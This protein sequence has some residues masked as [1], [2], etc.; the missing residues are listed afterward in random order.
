MLDPRTRAGAR[1]LFI[2]VVLLS[3]ALAALAFVA[4]VPSSG[5]EAATR[6]VPTDHRTIQGAVDHASPGDVV[7]V[8]QGIYQGSVVIPEELDDEVV[9]HGLHPSVTI[10][11]LSG[12]LL[13]VDDSSS[14]SRLFTHQIR[15][16]GLEI[17]AVDTS[18]AALDAVQKGPFSAVV[19]GLD[20]ADGS[21][22]YTVR[23][24]REVGYD[25]PILVFTAEISAA[26]L[27]DV[28]AA[29]ANELLGKPYEPGYV[30]F[31]LSEWLQQPSAPKA[32]LSRFDC[33][34]GMA[35]LLL[36]YI[37]ET[38]RLAQCL[39]AAIE[40]E[41]AAAVR[42]LC[43]KISGSG[44]HHGFDQLSVA[45]RDALWNL[46][47]AGDVHNALGPLRRI[48]C[49]CQRLQCSGERGR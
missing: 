22:V 11:T 9:A 44:S 16:T 32:V 20:L 6:I 39:A 38:Q 30:M 17:V 18:G 15:A 21:G 36:D 46:D 25:G 31:L 3:T 47:T 40:E 34:P 12:R 2:L 37:S 43:L 41:N 10:P 24:M 5:A 4:L 8:L 14:D 29:G 27:S 13:L 48:V 28:R 26:L 42:D 19:C 7:S 45:A 49:L 23:R 1:D 33:E 35:D